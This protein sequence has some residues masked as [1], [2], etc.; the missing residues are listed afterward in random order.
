MCWSVTPRRTTGVHA[1]FQ[2][3]RGDAG[4]ETI[5]EQATHALTSPHAASHPTPPTLPYP[6][7]SGF[8]PLNFT[9]TT[10]RCL[11]LGSY[12]YLGFAAADEYCTPRVQETLQELGVS[13]CSSRTDAGREPWCHPP[14]SSVGLL[15]RTVHPPRTLGPSP[16]G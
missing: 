16:H 12:N 15:I 7:H 10:K 4:L 13:T 6:P 1:C 3:Q 8:Y 2:G 14:P 5:L 9:G 11:N